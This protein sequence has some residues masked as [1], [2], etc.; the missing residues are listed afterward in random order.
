MFNANLHIL[1]AMWSP[2]T[3][4]RQG[5]FHKEVRFIDLTSRQASG[6]LSYYNATWTE[7]FNLKP[8]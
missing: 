2:W 5:Q 1:R 7:V 8:Y 4:Y 3:R 6:F